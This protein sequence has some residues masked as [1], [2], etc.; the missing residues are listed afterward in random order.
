MSVINWIS[1]DEVE[2]TNPKSMYWVKGP[3]GKVMM[4]YLNDYKSLGG[5][6][7]LWQN[8]GNDDFAM[9]GTEYIELVKPE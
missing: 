1:A 5:Y 2:P 8:L 6:R 3:D 4:C 7:N 9:E